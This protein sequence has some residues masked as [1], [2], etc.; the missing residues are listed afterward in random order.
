MS[1]LRPWARVL[2][3]RHVC[4]FADTSGNSL[5]VEDEPEVLSLAM[6]LLRLQGYIVLGTGDSRAVLRMARPR[7]EP[8]HLLLTD[9]VMPLMRGVQPAGRL[10]PIRPHVKI[11]FMSAYSIET[12]EDYRLVCG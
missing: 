6:D 4:P 7:V 3:T 10:A 1:L 9:G 5:G 2:C 12:V 11:L 8:I